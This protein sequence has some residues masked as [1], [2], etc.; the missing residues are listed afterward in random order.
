M[1]NIR[2]SGGIQVQGGVT[3]KSLSSS[4]LKLDMNNE[5][6]LSWGEYGNAYNPYW[7]N[8]TPSEDT[9]TYVFGTDFGFGDFKICASGGVN[10]LGVNTMSTTITSLIEVGDLV[11]LEHM[12]GKTIFT[13]DDS[14]IGS[15]PGYAWGGYPVVETTFADASDINVSTI[16]IVKKYANCSDLGLN[17][18]APYYAWTL[19]GS[20]TYPTLRPGVYFN[21]GDFTVTMWVNAQG[22]SHWAR[23]FDFGNNTS[24]NVIFGLKDTGLYPALVFSGGEIVSDTEIT[25]GSWSHLTVTYNHTTHSAK[26]YMDGVVVATGTFNPP[27]NVTRNNCYLGKSNWGNSLDPLLLGYLGKFEL[28]NTTMSDAEVLADYNKYKATY[29]L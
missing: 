26:M 24:N 9:K 10:Y 11:V 4:I 5:L 1:S 17:P 14:P 16:R 8:S 23:F 7:L 2:I 18:A 12:G 13:I 22:N 3:V 20:G 15:I 28:F 6:S 25:T 29:G 19:D 27:D 21:G